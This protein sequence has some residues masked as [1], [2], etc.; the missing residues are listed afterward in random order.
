[1]TNNSDQKSTAFKST[2]GSTTSHELSLIDRTIKYT[3]KAEW[4]I[5]FEKEE[6]VA[7]LFS[8][9]YLADT[10]ES[11][12]QRPITFIFNGGP[13]AASAYLHMGALG[14]KRVHFNTEGTLPKPPLRVLDNQE[15]WLCFSDLVFVDPVGTGFSRTLSQNK[16]KS[17]NAQQKDKE[18]TSNQAAAESQ[19]WEVERD[20]KSLAEFMENFLSRQNRWLSPIFIAGESYGGFRVARL[21]RQLQQ[22]FGIGLSGAILISPA[23][24]FSLLE[25]SDYN[26]SYWTSLVPSMAAAAAYHGRAKW[27][28]AEGDMEIHRQAAEHFSQQILLPIL[29]RGDSVPSPERQQVYQMLS[30]LIGLDVSLIERHQGRIDINIFSREL[31]RQEKK[32]VGLYDA[33]ITAIDPF[34]DRLEYSGSDPTLEGVQRLFTGAI[35]HHL[36]S[37]LNVET[38]LTYHLLNFDVFKEWQFKLKK[39]VKQGYVGAVD[40]LRVGMTL[41]PYMRVS[42]VHGIFDLLTTYFASQQLVALMK[43][44]PEVRSHLD[45]QCFDGGHMFYTWEA[46]RQ[47][48]FT[49]MTNFYQSALSN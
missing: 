20:L 32:I 25:G 26:L 47:Q 6:P 13:G 36:R 35:N 1:M 2:Q 33:A 46:S 41:N 38:E 22:E 37:T 17:D 34:P 7:E 5:L 42:I 24:E 14:P 40:D 18:E 10:S 15:S 48:W 9:A 4:Q 27:A 39:N 8:I 23:L 31:L 21:A 29:A 28:G 30:D 44:V 19:F 43:L 45:L 12:E 49:Y 3:A 16:D 11:S